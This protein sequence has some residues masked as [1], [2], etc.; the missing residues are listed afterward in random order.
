MIYLYIYSVITLVFTLQYFIP[1]G[2]LSYRINYQKFVLIS[3]GLPN[4]LLLIIF[5]IYLLAKIYFEFEKDC[6]KI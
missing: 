1:W 4:L 3:S 6:K 5:V 2:R